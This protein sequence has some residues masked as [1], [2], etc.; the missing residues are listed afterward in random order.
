MNIKPIITEKGLSDAKRGKF[1]FNVRGSLTK[2]ELKLM[3]QNV[4]GVHVT[5]IATMNK[6]R[7]SKRSYN[8]KV[9]TILGSKKV[10]VTL[11]DGE[12]IDLFEVKNQ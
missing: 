3:I 6:K 8:G 12:S 5:N 10:I 4:F 9:K 7:E 11:K 2:H 1:T